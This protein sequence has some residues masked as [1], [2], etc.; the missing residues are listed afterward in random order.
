V[1]VAA[2]PS[3]VESFHNHGAVQ[4]KCYVM[5]HQ[6]FVHVKQ[7][8]PDVQA[9]QDGTGDTCKIGGLS[10]SCSPPFVYSFH[11]LH[12]MPKPNLSGAPS[13]QYDRELIELCARSIAERTG[14]TLFGF[15]LIRPLGA[16]HMLLIDVNAFPSFKG[17]CDAAYALR[18]CLLELGAK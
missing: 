5:S 1:Q 3:V 7:S 18:A 2:C 9:A 4:L 16:D 12:S 10:A 15:D 14:L 17:I 11:S 6:V 8:F 13:M